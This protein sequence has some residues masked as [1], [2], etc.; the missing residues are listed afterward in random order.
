MSLKLTAEVFGALPEAQQRAVL[1]ASVTGLST[2][3][4]A[5]VRAAACRCLGNLAGFTQLMTNVSA[6]DLC[7]FQGNACSQVL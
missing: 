1:Q 3:K 7:C 2:D 4:E 6:P 5:S